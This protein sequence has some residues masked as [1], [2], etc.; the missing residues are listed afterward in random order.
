M[1]TAPLVLIGGPTA[2]LGVCRGIPTLPPG[3]PSLD[4]ITGITLLGAITVLSN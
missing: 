4:P 3:V 2:V 1:M